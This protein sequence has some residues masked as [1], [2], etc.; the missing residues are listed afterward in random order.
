[1][2]KSKAT[3]SLSRYLGPAENGKNAKESSLARLS[4]ENLSGLYCMWSGPHTAGLWWRHQILATTKV[5]GGIVWPSMLSGTVLF[6]ATKGT[7]QCRRMPSLIHCVRNVNLLKSS[8]QNK[9]I[10]GNFVSLCK[11]CLCGSRRF[12]RGW[13]GDTFVCRKRWVSCIFSVINF[14]SNFKRQLCKLK[15]SRGS[16]APASHLISAVLIILIAENL[17]SKA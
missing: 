2:H 3:T 6:L 14:L 4:L 8:L 13:G 12:F 5:P 10:V 16:P 15:F 11:K 1:M 17:I 7:G 9:Q